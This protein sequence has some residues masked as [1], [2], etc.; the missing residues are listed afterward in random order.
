MKEEWEIQGKGN[1]KGARREM[2]KEGGDRKREKEGWRK[3]DEY[4]DE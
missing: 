1:R 3:Q 4:R 2:E